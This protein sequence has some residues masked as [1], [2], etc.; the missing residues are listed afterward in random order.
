M[1][2][3]HDFVIVGAGTAGCVLAA[4][5]TEDPDVSVL[6]LEAGP[7]GRKLEIRIP[8]AFAKLF[9]SNVD[10]G[11]DT[12]PQAA[13]D[14]REIVFP[15]GR[16]LGGSAAIN[17]MMVLRGHPADQSAWGVPGWGRDD[18]APA[19]ERSRDSFPLAALR[20]PSLLTDAFVEA[21]AAAGIRRCPDLN[22][23]DP[24]GVG[25]VPVSQRNGRR[26]SV[27]DGYLKPA[28]RR[29]NLTVVTGCHV[30]R[31]LHERGVAVGVAYL[32]GGEEEEAQAG[33]EVI[34]AAGAVNTP[35]L[36]L[37]SGIGPREELERHGID[38]AH[39]LPGVG[40]NL[41][42]HLANGIL[43]RTRGVQTLYSAET[44]PNLVRWLAGGRGPLTSN[45][46]EA[47]AFV[48]TDPALEA[49][50]LELL[51][52]P[53]LFEE[54]G[55][56][57][58]SAHGFTV[59]S[60]LLQP[61][62]VGEVRLRSADPLAA[63]VIDPRYLSDESGED[64]GKLVHGVRL[65]RELAATEP[66]AGYVEAELLPGAEARDDEALL[67]H[68][69]ARSQTLYHPVGTCRLGLDDGAVVDPGL[70]VRGIDRLRVIDASVI[71]RPP[72]GH[73]NWPTVMVAERGAEIVAA[74][75]RTGG[76]P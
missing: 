3:V 5:L 43:V 32:S 20:E 28:R 53:V 66:L 68:V 35:Q 42:D 47:V 75:A 30:T 70:R 31:V 15:R 41:L 69:R 8:A 14:E 18:V 62:S 55:L 2:G 13:L 51:F 60:I 50:D 16:V 74:S 54:E 11:Y 44:L 37:L 33:R 63:P 36:L 26:F 67:A 23:D 64:A 58:P 34:L 46:A 71:P 52:A 24:V 12:A 22:G 29:P 65:A 57:K 40:R 21:A 76:H 17:A 73:T 49:P 9:R 19:Y 56:Q 39:H 72:R 1:A 61:R 25:T 10:W 27:A 6:L 59:A 48:K 45:V 4:R 7:E 38:V